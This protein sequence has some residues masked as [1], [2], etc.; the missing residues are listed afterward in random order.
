MY[1]I[2]PRLSLWDLCGLLI[3]LKELVL[4]GFLTKVI[5]VSSEFFLLS[6]KNRPSSCI[7]LSINAFNTAEKLART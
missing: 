6:T 5:L 4:K 3:F 7:R 1:F 2:M